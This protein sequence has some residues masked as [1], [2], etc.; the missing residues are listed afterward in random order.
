MAEVI[1][2]FLKLLK[3]IILYLDS[4]QTIIVE[5]D[6]II[7]SL[8][9]NAT[10]WRKTKKNIAYIYRT[11]DILKNHYIK[12]KGLNLPLDDSKFNM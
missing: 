7:T 3:T 11:L 10:W 5:L 12:I 1:I 6:P 2:C 4:I 9:N 8:T